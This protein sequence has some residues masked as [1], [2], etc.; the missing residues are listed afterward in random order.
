M[1]Q[2]GFTLIELLVVMA[3]T[4]ILGTLTI[5]GF[6]SYKQVQVLQTSTNEV[7]TMLNEAKSRAQS[8]VKLGSATKCNDVN[9][10]LVDYKVDVSRANNNYKLSID[11]Q[12]SSQNPFS[13]ILETKILPKNVSFTSSTSFSFPV[14]SGGVQTP[15]SITISGSGKTKTITVNALGGISTQ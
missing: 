14:L 5:A 8:Q 13:E 2:K 9:K 3:I 4:V 10:N 11:C 7:V 6:D 15:G 12:D 1:K